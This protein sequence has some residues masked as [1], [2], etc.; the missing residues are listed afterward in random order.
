ME[1]QYERENESSF[2]LNYGDAKIIKVNS[3]YFI[4]NKIWKQLYINNDPAN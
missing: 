2:V 4:P 1:L 3:Y